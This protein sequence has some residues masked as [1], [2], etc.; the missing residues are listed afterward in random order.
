MQ[1]RKHDTHQRVQSRLAGLRTRA[2]APKDLVHS[3]ALDEVHVNEVH[4]R[5]DPLWRR[6]LQSGRHGVQERPELRTD[7]LRAPAGV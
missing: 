5:I 7:E 2:R 3:Q 4:R 6:A 1:R